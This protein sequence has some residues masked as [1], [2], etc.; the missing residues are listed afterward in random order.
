MDAI[1][2]AAEMAVLI[3]VTVALPAGY[4]QNLLAFYISLFAIN[5]HTYTL[6]L[7]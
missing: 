7:H 3:S 4:Y 5:V 1:I 6:S 2:V